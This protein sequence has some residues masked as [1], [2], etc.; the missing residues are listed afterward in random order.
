[1]PVVPFHQANFHLIAVLAMLQLQLL[2]FMK[3]QICGSA[4][5]IVGYFS[6]ILPS[7]FTNVVAAVK[8]SAAV[9]A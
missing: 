9:V 7:L 4:A 1:M 8:S 6:S 3:S 5:V 2:C